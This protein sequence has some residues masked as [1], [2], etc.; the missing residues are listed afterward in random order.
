MSDETTQNDITSNLIPE[1]VLEEIEKVSKIEKDLRFLQIRQGA[2]EQSLDGLR[3]N[4]GGENTDVIDESDWKKESPERKK[5]VTENNKLKETLESFEKK[6]YENIGVEFAKGAERVFKELQKAQELKKKMSTS[7]V[8]NFERQENEEEKKPEKKKKK[9]SFLTLGLAITAVAGVLYLFRDKIEEIIPGFKEG[10]EKM[11][12]PLKNI[13]KAIFGDFIDNVVSIFDGAFGSIFSGQDGIKNTLNTFFLHTLP[14]VLYQSGI[15]LFS[16][17]GGSV[18]T[19]LRT[20]TNNQVQ[21]SD[22]AIEQ[23]QQEEARRE[24]IRREAAQNAVVRTDVFATTGQ[25]EKAQ[26]QIGRD[27][28]IVSQLDG[29][30]ANLYEVEKQRIGEISSYS[31]SF[32]NLI[33]KQRENIGSEI[34]DEESL[35]LAAMFWE[36]NGKRAKNEDGSYTSEFSSWHNTV[37][38]MNVNTNNWQSLINAA[39]Q[40]RRNVAN[41][42]V[43]NKDRARLTEIQNQSLNSF[44]GSALSFSGEKNSEVVLNVKPV[45]IAQDAFAAKAVSL[46]E[47]FKN[48]FSGK[49]DITISTMTNSV[50]SFIEK[51]INDLISPLLTGM[52]SFVQLFV[53]PPPTNNGQEVS[54]SQSSSGS[55]FSRL[56]GNTAQQ[57]NAS[58]NP[59]ILLDLQLNGN[60]LSSISDMFTKE[61]E[62]LKTMK[63][64]N[65]KLSAIKALTIS[66]K[67]E[68]AKQVVVQKDNQNITNNISV[69]NQGDNQYITNNITNN[70]GVITQGLEL[71]ERRISHIEAY[72]E[73]ND[74]DD[75]SVKNFTYPIQA[76]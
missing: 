69:T 64:T 47:T 34:S 20:M 49:N 43:L 17:F 58:N 18:S 37:W 13:G 7:K 8:E 65:T 50:V 57:Y 12:Q 46:F 48:L 4:I 54:L 51:V 56:T 11:L 22:K 67:G 32:L 5:N 70:I 66:S 73:A 19:N 36:Q 41:E 60:I 6:R 1:S 59:I 15:A 35:Q 16:A 10:Y 53:T 31:N 38:K 63:D 30:V 62:L 45:D 39:D 76:K 14:D 75:D 61:E 68:T 21:V 42:S 44:R 28:V 25:I 24:R 2:V 72:L 27:I 29:V 74:I 40:F 71:C 55:I 9:I 26:R 33:D 3:E 23:G 52:N